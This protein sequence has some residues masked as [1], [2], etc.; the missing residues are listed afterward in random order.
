MMNHST[1]IPRTNRIPS[2]TVSLHMF[3]RLIS[4]QSTTMNTSHNSLLLSIIRSL[5]RVIH[6]INNLM[7]TRITTH[8]P[9]NFIMHNNIQVITKR[10][11]RRLINLIILPIARQLLLQVNTF[12][13]TS[14][15]SRHTNQFRN[16]HNYRNIVNSSYTGDILHNQRAI[17]RRG[18]SF[19]H[20]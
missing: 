19:L 17:H 4:S 18:S 7:M 11:I 6:T 2:G 15:M 13:S 3:K 10:N 8:A 14:T 20:T 9:V 12:R 1:R 16:R 5:H